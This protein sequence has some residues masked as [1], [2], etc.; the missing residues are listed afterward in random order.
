[1]PEFLERYPDIALDIELTDSVVD[2]LEQRMD[3]AVRAGPLKSSSLLARKLGETRKVIVGA[4]A[5]LERV[6]TPSNPA[7]LEHHNLIAPNYAR[8]V[9]V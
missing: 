5:Y 9:K 3:V 4:P 8:V 7:E 6:G 1:M 2:I